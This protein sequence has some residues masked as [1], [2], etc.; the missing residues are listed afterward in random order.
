MR[1]NWKLM[2]LFASICVHSR[3]LKKAIGRWLPSPE[4]IPK[5]AKKR[6][7]EFN[8]TIGVNWCPFAV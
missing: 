5:T 6:E 4:T 1:A 3:F 2:K 7:A 8:G